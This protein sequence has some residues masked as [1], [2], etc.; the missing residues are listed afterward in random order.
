[1]RYISVPNHFYI[2]F[3]EPFFSVKVLC[4]KREN[5][6]NKACFFCIFCKKHSLINFSFFLL[7]CYISLLLLLFKHC[8][9]PERNLTLANFLVLLLVC[10]E[11]SSCPLCLPFPRNSAV[12]STSGFENWLWMPSCFK[13]FSASFFLSLLE[14]DLLWNKWHC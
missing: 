13:G 2:T 8:Y 7:C 1:M 5:I 3:F 10:L 14:L 6:N 9:H 11:V 12:K 4:Q